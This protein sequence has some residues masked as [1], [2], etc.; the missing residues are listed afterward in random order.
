MSLQRKSS[1][2]VADIRRSPLPPPPH[3][4][5]TNSVQ[6]WRRSFPW[7]DKPAEKSCQ[8]TMGHYTLPRAISI[9]LFKFRAEALGGGGGRQRG[10][11]KY[12]HCSWEDW[13]HAHTSSTK[14]LK[15]LTPRQ[16]L[17]PI[18]GLFTSAEHALQ[19]VRTDVLHSVYN[20]A[21]IYWRHP[22][23][24]YWL[25]APLKNTNF[26][27]CFHVRGKTGCANDELNLVLNQRVYKSVG[28]LI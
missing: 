4:R 22:K 8:V 17:P 18:E 26:L 6:L 5:T 25:I 3:T 16:Y 13:A 27:G 23:N 12:T 7:K 24:G 14:L 20:R 19:K 9:C 21:S 15:L 10:V 2:R 11:R 28:F 1:P